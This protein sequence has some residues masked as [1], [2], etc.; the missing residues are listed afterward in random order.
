[1]LTFS[2]LTFGFVGSSIG[3]QT[4]NNSLGIFENQSD[5]GS[6]TPPGTATFHAAT[7]VYTI[8]SAGEDLRANVDEFHFVWRKVSGDVSLTADVKVADGSAISNPHCKAL[9]I[10]RQTLDS[11]ALFAVGAQVRRRCNTG[12]PRAT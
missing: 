4:A 10:L 11:D 6:V 7:G 9:L 5:V 1:M 12:V 8:R 3:A 2:A